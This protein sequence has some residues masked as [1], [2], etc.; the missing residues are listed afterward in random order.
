MGGSLSKGGDCR[1]GACFWF[2]NNIEIT[3]NATLPKEFWSVTNGGSP[4]VFGRSPWRSPGNAKVL[5]SGCG[6]AGGGPKRFANGGFAPE[7]FSQG[8]DGKDAPEVEATVW[9]LGSTVEVAWAIAANHGGG[10]NYRLCKK[11]DGI[12]EEC[13]Q[14]TPLKFAGNTSFIINPNGSTFEFPMTKVTQGTVPA[15]SE[16]ARDPVPGCKICEDAH[17]HCGAPMTPVPMDQPGGGSSDPWNTQVDC[18]AACCGSTSS[19]AHG[20]CPDGTEFYPAISGHSGFGKNVPEWSIMDKVIIP[21][22]LAEGDY[23]LSWRWDCEESTQVWQNCADI[24]LTKDTPP[25]T[26]KPAPTPAPTPAPKPKPGQGCKKYENPTCHGSF[27][28]AKKCW[29]SGCSKCHDETTFN[30][31]VCCSGCDLTTKAGNVTYCDLHKSESA[32]RFETL[33]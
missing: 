11:S 4:D 17:S 20:V 2:T 6:V 27:T 13:F 28:E 24:R 15:G 14:R 1:N 30:C 12:T 22:Q 26:P 18:Y 31:D 23:L 10:Y 19:K 29:F 16:W 5:G 33:V 21:S 32:R 3:G 25:P 8:A 7:G 9:Q